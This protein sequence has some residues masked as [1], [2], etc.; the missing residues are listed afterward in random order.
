MAARQP[1]ALVQAGLLITLLTGALVAG[2]YAWGHVSHQVR[3][4]EMALADGQAQ[5]Q[6]HA[7]DAAALTLRR[8]IAVAEGLPANRS[9][10]QELVGSCVWSSGPSSPQTTH[11]GRAH[12]LSFRDGS[13]AWGTGIEAGKN[14]AQSLGTRVS[15]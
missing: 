14:N 6:S 7:Y 13:F 4:A 10:L 9:L 5:L 2:M 12:P 3:E 1:H 15:S 8:G 11:P